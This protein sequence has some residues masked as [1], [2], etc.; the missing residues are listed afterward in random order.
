MADTTIFNLTA[1]T[2]TA[3]GDLLPIVD[4]SDTAQSANGSTR[5]I[6]YANFLAGITSLGN[7]ATIQGHTF[8]LTGAFIRSGAHSLTLTT[9]GAT[10]VTFPTTGTLAT[11]AGTESLSNKTF[12]APALGT[13]ASG[14]LTN[15]TGL[16][17]G[18]G[19]S[20]LGSNVATFLATPSSAN[21]RAAITDETGDGSL[22]FSSTPV[23][24]SASTNLDRATHGNRLIVVDTGAVTLTV[25]DDTAGSWGAGDVVY[26]INTSTGNV[27]LAADSTGT[28]N[29][30]TASAGSTLTVYPGQSFALSRTAA[31]AWRGGAEAPD[32]MV[33]PIGDETTAITTGTAKVTF[34]FP[35]AGRLVDLRASLTTASSSGTPTFDL[36]EGGTT[37]ISTKLTIDANELTSTTAAAA[38][39]I[40][41]AT[42]ADDAQ[43]TI[44]VDTA[45]TGAAGAKIALY[46]L[47]TA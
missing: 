31:N 38:H 25:L 1:T 5:K 37:M 23:T 24:L 6:T 15:C 19:V 14:T 17:I 36:N 27:T 8:T 22:V 26:G 13:P 4:V 12:V 2:A 16:P 7:L 11:L 30:V 40:S 32:V 9:S 28:T 33:I 42:F 45:G 43:G 34:R 35:Y 18:T 20:G 21:L 46:M 39:V 41:D 3:S 29:T 47:R 10:N 44:D